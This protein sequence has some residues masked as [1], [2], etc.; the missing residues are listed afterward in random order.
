[1]TRA[2]AS[3]DRGIITLGRKCLISQAVSGTSSDFTAWSIPG[4]MLQEEEGR[5]EGW[6]I[7]GTPADDG[8]EPKTEL[9]AHTRTGKESEA[10]TQDKLSAV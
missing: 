9:Q 10:R 3:G 1:M 8:A 6:C 5:G 2:G 4:T 7:L